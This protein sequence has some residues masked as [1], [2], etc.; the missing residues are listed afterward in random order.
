MRICVGPVAVER[1]DGL[2]FGNGL[3]VSVLCAQHLAFSEMC[4]RA[5][6]RCGERSLG[7]ALRA[8]TFFPKN[9]RLSQ[10]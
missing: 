9:H 4:Q 5:A 8:E 1:D 6:G 2:V 3:V 7:Q 10:E